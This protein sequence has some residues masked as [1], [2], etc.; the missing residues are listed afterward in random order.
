MPKS[1]VKEQV[2]IQVSIRPGT[3]SP[4]RKAAWRRFWQKLIAEAKA[5]D[6]S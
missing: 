5:G 4:A 1:I 6:R 2:K 3:V